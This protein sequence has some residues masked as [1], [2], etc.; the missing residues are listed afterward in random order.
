[1]RS[2]RWRMALLLACALTPVAYAQ[3]GTNA[4]ADTEYVPRLGDIMTAIQ[5][6]HMKLW[7]AGKSLNWGL[8]AYELGQ[9]KA[10]LVEAASMYTGI[11]A[12]NVNTMGDP[13]QSI[14]DAIEARDSRRFSRAVGELTAGCN[15][16]HQSMGHGYIV[17]RVPDASPFSDQVFAPQDKR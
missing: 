14:S 15:A 8:A 10:G 13:V 7:F 12:A 1:M 17:M 2:H 4:A 16:C 11:P 6:R 5:T 3:S 9:I